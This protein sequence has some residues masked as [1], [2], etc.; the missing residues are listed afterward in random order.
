MNILLSCN[1]QY[2]FPTNVLIKSILFNNTD[3]DI[4]FWIMHDI[5]DDLIDKISSVCTDPRCKIHDI[6][7]DTS[8]FGEMVIPK[9]YN[10]HVSIETYFR[11]LILDYLPNNLERVLYMDTDTI[12]NKNLSF[13]YSVDLKNNLLAACED[14]GFV[15]RPHIKK[16]VYHNLNFQDDDLYFNAGVILFNLSEIRKTY[17]TKE[18]LNFIKQN[19]DRILFHDQDVINKIF[20]GRILSLPITMNCRPFFF[21]YTYKME[22]K[23]ISKAYIIHYGPKPWNI[24][25]TGTCLDLFWHYAFLAGYEKEYNSIKNERKRYISFRWPSLIKICLKQNLRILYA[26]IRHWDKRVNLS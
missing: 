20:H 18:I 4:N 15:L 26:R 8:V 10:Q 6:A 21:L 3:D 12:C 7:I 14:Y 9:K 13:I 16:Q 22:K 24:K 17:T 25:Y 2:V 11:L 19:S 5:Q 1:S 23:I